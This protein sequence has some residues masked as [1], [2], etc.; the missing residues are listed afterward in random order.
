MRLM[1]FKGLP[2]VVI[3]NLMRISKL[4]LVVCAS[5]LHS[6]CRVTS[7]HTSSCV[8][9]LGFTN[10]LCISRLSL[11]SWRLLHC[12]YWSLCGFPRLAFTHY[13]TC[14]SSFTVHC[15][16]VSFHVL[17]SRH[18]RFCESPRV[19]FFSLYFLW[20]FTYCIV[21]TVVFVSPQVLHCHHC[22]LR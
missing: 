15:S 3:R 21:V 12:R 14:E 5:A 17:H 19:A 8:S 18:C 6:R 9:F 11:V 20:V 22:G 2:Q 10:S 4:R 7:H 1:L 13:S 16:L